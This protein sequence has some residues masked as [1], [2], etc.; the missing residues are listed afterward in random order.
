MKKKYSLK[1]WVIAILFFMSIISSKVV[2]CRGLF[3]LEKGFKPDSLN[4]SPMLKKIMPS[5]VRVL[6]EY[7][8]EYHG[9]YYDDSLD[10]NSINL[11]NNKFFSKS[12]G[13]I[14]IKD[15]NKVYKNY[16]ISSNKSKK[17]GSGVIIDSDNAYVITNYHVIS[18][19]DKI[20]VIL[21]DG[22]KY[23]AKVVGESK[24]M[25][26]AMLHLINSKN[27]SSIKIANSNDIHIGN[28]CVAIG[29]PYNLKNSVSI[30][31]VSALHRI[32]HEDNYFDNYIQ[33]DAAINHG[34]S[35]GPLVN[36]NGELIGI[37]S[38]ILSGEDNY[39]GNIGIGFAIPSDSV[40]LFCSQILKYG[41]LNIHSLSIKFSDFKFKNFKSLKIP[42]NTGVLINSVEKHSTA[43][44]CGLKPGDI[45][46]SV[47]N[48]P[49]LNSTFLKMQ[50][51]T[52]F[53]S[54][55]ISFMLYRNGKLLN[56]N[57][58]L[59]N[60]KNIFHYGS[61]LHCKL[62]G[63][64]LSVYNRQRLKDKLHSKRK[65]KLFCPKIKGII[66]NS[67]FP[68]SSARSLG[69]RVND[70]IIGVNFHKV[71]TIDNLKKYLSLN[72]KFIV[73]EI[74]RKNKIYF[75]TV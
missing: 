48:I 45:L 72:K 5:V 75:F 33:T 53:Q 18:D 43:E 31:I 35:G 14:N 26:L 12:N 20:V 27:L 38:S 28:Y 51:K 60:K 11:S 54:N 61:R 24:E 57:V 22:R 19:S 25:D 29:S 65:E 1:F 56:L 6:T 55:Y 16:S 62:G 69:L 13:S 23:L 50:I 15:M 32:I 71:S 74:M 41:R 21:T 47:S 49:I 52:N 67:F 39:G 73:L 3:D 63:S 10:I 17:L 40:Y 7:H 59:E 2:E 68:H 37:N 58:E 9:Y 46:V 8:K 30:G 34:N 44:K 64:V 66:V 42:Y 70:I 4:L 36:L